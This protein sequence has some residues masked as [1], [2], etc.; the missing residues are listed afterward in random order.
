M[1]TY[2]CVLDATKM[3]NIKPRAGIKCTS[4]AFRVHMLTITPPRLP[5]VTA[6][7]TPTCL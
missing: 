7:P 2:I 6:P 1:C 5:D 3:G 4:L